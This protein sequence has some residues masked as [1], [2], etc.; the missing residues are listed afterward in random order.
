MAIQ[1]HA[2]A[3]IPAHVIPSLISLAQEADLGLEAHAKLAL[4]LILHV[5]DHRVNVGRG[6]SAQIDHEPCVLL[7]H[8]RAANLIPLQTGIGD[9]LALRTLERRARAGFIERL[10]ALALV[11]ELVHAGADDVEVALAQGKGRRQNHQ[12]LVLDAT[13]AI[14]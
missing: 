14:A 5:L 12:A 2:L 1:P 4:H 13:R 6:R 9:E 7:R 10:L 11:C 3:Y 8:C